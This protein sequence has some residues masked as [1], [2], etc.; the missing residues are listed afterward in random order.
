MNPE[1]LSDC[2]SRTTMAFGH[3]KICVCGPD[4]D[5][6]RAP[7]TI[8]AIKLK[9]AMETILN[10]VLRGENNGEKAA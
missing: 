4:C 6:T 9:V 7:L 8:F 1:V 10:A 3:R 5:L 2:R